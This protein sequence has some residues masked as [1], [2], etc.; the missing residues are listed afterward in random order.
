[1]SSVYQDSLRLLEE[2]AKTHDAILVGF[3]GGKDSLVVLDLCCKTFKRVVAFYK[4]LV[5]GLPLIERQLDI[6]R[7]R[8]GVQ[9]LQYPHHCFFDAM[10][11]G[12][13]CNAA[14][15]LEG[16]EISLENSFAWPRADTG[17]E[18]VA[19]GMKASDGL[20]RRQF[21]ANIHS[22]DS[23]VWK[24]LV[25]PIE[26]WKKFDVLT[27][28]KVNGIPL[29][30]SEKGA[31]TSGVDLTVESILWLHDKYPEDFKLLLKWFPYAMAV[32]KRREFHGIE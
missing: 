25:L 30:P 18:L 23:P 1:M 28:L 17:I 11:E 20:K 15:E 27:Y 19:T 32:V 9:V 5:P 26:H 16:V 29:P 4:W 12:V 13:F 24:N 21:F 22:S 3:S 2:H 8:Y 10:R 31:V 6:A 7:T 14:P